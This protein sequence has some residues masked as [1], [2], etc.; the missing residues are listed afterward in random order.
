MKFPKMFLFCDAFRVIIEKFFFCETGRHLS[1]LKSLYAIFI[2]LIKLI[3][4]LITRKGTTLTIGFIKLFY[5][6]VR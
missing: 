4:I 3:R 5:L 1:N 6:C 2:S